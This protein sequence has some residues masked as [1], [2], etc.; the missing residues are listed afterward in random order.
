MLKCLLTLHFYILQIL[1]TARDVTDHVFPR[2]V[3]TY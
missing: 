3:I 2:Q 1:S